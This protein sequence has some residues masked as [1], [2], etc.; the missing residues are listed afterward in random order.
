[1]V[2]FFEK[3]CVKYRFKFIIT[4][5]LFLIQ[6]M[7]FIE[8]VLDIF[9]ITLLNYNSI[10]IFIDKLYYIFYVNIL[11]SMIIIYLLL[12]KMKVSSGF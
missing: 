9:H 12:K 4:L 8:T 3:E 11:N 1:M 7:V 10:P 5:L 2:I 6:I